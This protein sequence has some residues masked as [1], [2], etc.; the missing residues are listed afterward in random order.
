[1]NSNC[2]FHTNQSHLHHPFHSLYK[3][4]M[5][6]A[7]VILV[8]AILGLVGVGIVLLWGRSL[9]INRKKNSLEY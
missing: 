5:L 7:G 9:L 3:P 1:M 4:I 2:F 8:F 6:P